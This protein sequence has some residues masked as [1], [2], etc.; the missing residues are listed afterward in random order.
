AAAEKFRAA[1]LD[2][3]RDRKRLLAVFD[4]ARTSND[5]EGAVA[6]FGAVAKI[7]NR[8]VGTQIERD[9][10]VR[11]GDADRFG[12]AG[13]IFELRE[14]DRSLIAGDS[15]RG[16]VRAGHDMRAEPERLDNA[17][18]IIDLALPGAGVH[19]DEHGVKGVYLPGII[20]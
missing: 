5:R 16:A 4:R 20:P 10:F 19:Y 1:A 11:L 17:N 12:N 13:D 3:V 6:D 2:H 8:A 15:D 18:H 14:I 9:Q 7:D